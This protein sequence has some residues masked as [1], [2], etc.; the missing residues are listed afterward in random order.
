[1]WL[2]PTQRIVGKRKTVSV[3]GRG[4]P[5]S[6]ESCLY[7]RASSWS[8]FPRTGQLVNQDPVPTPSPPLLIQG[9]PPRPRGKPRAAPLHV[10]PRGAPLP[11]TS[12]SGTS[13]RLRRLLPAAAAPTPPAPRS[14]TRPA[15]RAD[16]AAPGTVRL[17]SPRGAG[18]WRGEPGRTRVR[19]AISRGLA[20]PAPTTGARAGQG[21]PLPTRTLRSGAWRAA[22]ARGPQGSDGAE[23]ANPGGWCQGPQPRLT[24]GAE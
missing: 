1:M 15:G 9:A 8:G 2:T 18:S 21:E 11:K 16:P 12:A 22:L 6:H 23:A 19:T 4:H 24:R 3:S 7:S 10:P 13:R 14:G 17:G 5:H 20:P